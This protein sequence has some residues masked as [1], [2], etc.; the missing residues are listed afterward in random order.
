MSAIVSPIAIIDVECH[1][2]ACV[3]NDLLPDPLPFIVTAAVRS[4]EIHVGDQIVVIDMTISAF[5]V[6]EGDAAN[7]FGGDETVQT[8]TSSRSVQTIR[9][10]P[11]FFVGKIQSLTVKLIPIPSS[12]RHI[13]HALQ[14][15]SLTSKGSELS[16]L[17]INIESGIVEFLDLGMCPRWLSALGET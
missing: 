15:Q 9:T 10:S 3:R 4:V 14:P 17:A 8:I 6:R 13:A 5:D 16:I 2:D 1:P 7:Q 12:T 11:L